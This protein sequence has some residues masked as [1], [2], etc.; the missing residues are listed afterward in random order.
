M[1]SI[2]GIYAICNTKTGEAYVGM[3]RYFMMRAKD[4]RSALDRGVHHNRALQAAWTTDGATVFTLLLLRRYT[5]RE[6]P[7]A[8]KRWLAR[9]RVAGVVLYNDQVR[10][11]RKQAA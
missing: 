7:L 8:E 2:S 5:W 6:L 1:E 10:R 9:A 4:H 11:G 3:A